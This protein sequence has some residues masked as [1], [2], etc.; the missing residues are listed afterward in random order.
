MAGPRGVQF[1]AE[2]ATAYLQAAGDAIVVIDDRGS[3]MVVNE[4]AEALF[5]RRRAD[6]LGRDI[7]TVVRTALT[8]AKDRSESV[9]VR[10]DG[11]EL[12][13]EVTVTHLNTNAR[14][15]TAVTIRDATER[16]RRREVRDEFLYRSSHELRT[17]IATMS[18]L[19][20]TLALRMGQMS[21]ADVA[22]ALGALERQGDRA[23]VL[24]DNLFDLVQLDTGR[25][26]LHLEEV[27]VGPVLERALESE[28]PP[29]GTSVSIECDRGVAALADSR[30]LER[31]VVNL[32]SNAYRYGGTTISILVSA[33]ADHVRITVADDGPGVEDDLVETVF[34][35]FTRGTKAGA[36]GGSGVGLAVCRRFVEAFGGWLSYEAVPGGAAFTISLRLTDEP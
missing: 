11:S 32:L 31:V 27:R 35:P 28:A 36:F 34:D 12:P 6:L 7:E 3:I 8:E 1:E 21:E 5:D 15:L 18:A 30:Q 17:P 14:R 20:S 9:G 13:I 2:V 26:E 19:A 4:R 33:D 24:L 25:S 22:T 23:S 10:S 29:E 16:Q